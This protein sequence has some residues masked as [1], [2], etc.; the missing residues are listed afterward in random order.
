[1]GVDF[2][3][4]NTILIGNG[5]CDTANGEED[6]SPPY[7][8]ADGITGPT[9]FDQTGE[10]PSVLP[11]V[12]GKFSALVSKNSIELEWQTI[13]EE[14]FDFFSIERSNDGE[15]FYEI[16]TVPGHGNSNQP[17]DYS[18]TDDNPIFGKSYYRL[19]AIDYDG[20]YEKFQILSVE[21]IPDALQISI[22]P[23]PS[24][25]ENM[26]ILL[27]LPVEAQIKTIDVYSF[28]GELILKKDLQS[29][30]NNILLDRQ[31]PKGLYYAKIQ[32]DN[33]TESRKLIIN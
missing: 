18:F 25:S 15:N 17:I 19:N 33:F 7:C 12:L 23:N 6:T 32:I 9:G 5:G 30:L 29:G 31:L 27:A 20:S 3:C 10:T 28:S 4:G 2:I 14:N 13:T 26:N 21:F 16:G 22:Y 8:A 24:K 11:I 1:M